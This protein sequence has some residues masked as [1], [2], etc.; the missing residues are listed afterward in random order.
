MVLQPGHSSIA[1]PVSWLPFLDRQPLARLKTPPTN[2]QGIFEQEVTVRK[3]VVRSR[4]FLILCGETLGE[5]ETKL[6]GASLAL[7]ETAECSNEKN[8]LSAL[9]QLISTLILKVIERYRRKSVVTFA[10]YG[11]FRTRW[12]CQ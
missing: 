3:I 1:L 11:N 6:P 8:N 10:G 4:V 7:G 12:S 5:G 9:F 2:L